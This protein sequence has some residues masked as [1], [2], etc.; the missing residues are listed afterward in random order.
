[1]EA[2]TNGCS[3]DHSLEDV[4][5]K[6]DAIEPYLPAS[7]SQGLPGYMEQERTQDELNHVFHLLKKYDLADDEEQAR[8]NEEFR[9]LLQHI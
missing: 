3:I 5:K 4:R 8:R 1:M 7:I 2:K 6:L 9:K